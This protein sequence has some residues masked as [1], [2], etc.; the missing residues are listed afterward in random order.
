M[1]L[2]I[3]ISLLLPLPFPL[4]LLPPPH[5]PP[6]PI[7][8]YESIDKAN[9]AAGKTTV[10]SGTPVNQPCNTL[11][12]NCEIS[13]AVSAA[14]Q[15]DV[16]VLCLGTT[17]QNDPDSTMGEGRDRESIDLPGSQT[18]LADAV[19][20]T[21]KPVV[22][23]LVNG[24]IV[25]IDKYVAKAAAVVEAFMPAKSR[26]CFQSLWPQSLGQASD[27]VLRVATTVENNRHGYDWWG[28]G[29]P[30][31]SLLQGKGAFQLR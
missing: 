9:G 18:A 16:V 13:R 2:L 20:A 29:R 19:F 4:P 26:A 7:S 10:V 6:T 27:N 17:A 3:L 12:T 28:W 23:V 31:I 14:R 8:I 25:A 15:A 5:T 1:F 21:G 30:N 22:L 24:G 11:G